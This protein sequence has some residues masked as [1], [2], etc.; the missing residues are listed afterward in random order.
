MSKETGRRLTMDES[1]ARALLA[2]VAEAE[3]PPTQVSVSLAQRQGRSKLRRRR[4]I[5]SG[6][7]ALA[8]VAVA[9]VLLGGTLRGSPAGHHPARP[10]APRTLPPAVRTFNPLVPYAEFGW[11][12]AGQ[13]MIAGNLGRVSQDLVAGRG[14]RASWG[15]TVVSQGRCH[16]SSGQISN[17][18]RRGGHPT[19]NCSLGMSGGLS[20]PVTRQLRPV[21]GHPAFLAGSQLIWEYAPRSWAVLSGP[22]THPPVQAVAKVADGITFG[23]MP[24]PALEFP[25]Q[26]TGL[27]AAWGIDS[28]HFHARAGALRGRQLDLAGAGGTAQPSITV[29]LSGPGSSCFFYPDGQSHHRVIDGIKVVV[30]RLPSR[31]HSPATFQVCAPHAHG[32]DV[33]VST[34][35]HQRPGAVSIF[36]HHLRLLGVVPANWTTNPLR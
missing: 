19:L 28:A 5:M 16:P 2:R 23:P 14:S 34:Y 3:T 15:L 9:T 33:F 20:V 21:N 22:G 4:V 1:Q 12:P 10:T 36:S 7:P 25:V 11:L 30:N 8:A 35:G 18:L 26:L 31:P 6:A 13:S 17:Q 27:P 32:L 29:G 24:A